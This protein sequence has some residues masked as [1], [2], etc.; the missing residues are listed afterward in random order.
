MPSILDGNL[1]GATHV[2]NSVVRITP[3]RVV[4]VI[5]DVSQGLAG[6]T[7]AAFGRN[8]EDRTVLYVTTNGGMSAPPPAEC[9][10]VE[11]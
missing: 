11:W 9:N 3:Q 8:A 1:Y 2:Y 5:A 7:A 6:S 4:T 10:R